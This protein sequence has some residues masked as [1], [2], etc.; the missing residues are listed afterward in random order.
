MVL[1]ASAPLV[2]QIGEVA[3]AI[4]HLLDEAGPLPLT[5]I[6]KEIDAPRDIVMQGIGWL[7]REDK[8]VVEEDGRR[9][10]AAL[11]P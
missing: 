2:E 7:A 6:V 4:W 8:L 10:I 1:V 5:Q 9:K 3:G 11:L